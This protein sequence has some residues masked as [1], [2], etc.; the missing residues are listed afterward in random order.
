MEQRDDSE[1]RKLAYAERSTRMA[2][3]QRVLTGVSTSESL[4]G[5]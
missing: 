4:D 2:E 1:P 3:L 5:C